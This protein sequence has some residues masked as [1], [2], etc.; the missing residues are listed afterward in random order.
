MRALLV[1][2]LHIGKKLLRSTLGASATRRQIAMLASLEA[3][4]VRARARY[5]I[6]VGDVFD[7][8]APSQEDMSALVDFWSTSKLRWIVYPG[9]H[10]VDDISLKKGETFSRRSSLT[11]LSRLPRAGALRNVMF[12]RTAKTV[13]IEGVRL[14]VV[15]WGHPMA[16]PKGT[17]L[18]LF[19]DSLVGAKRD[20]GSVV[21][22]GEG[23][24]SAA[25]RGFAAV[26]GHLHTPQRVRRTLFCGT[27]AQMSWGE[28]PVKQLYVTTVTQDF[29][30]HETIPW[31][32]PWTLRQVE[33]SSEAPPKLDDARAY[34]KLVV[35]N[36]QRVDPNWLV[37][38][39]N[40]ARVGGK[41]GQAKQ[42]R[43]IRQTRDTRAYLDEWLKRHTS[44]TD[45]QRAVALKIDARMGDMS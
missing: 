37:N 33:W 4:A 45:R 13:V 8:A 18:V 39:P 19:H 42:P 11:L 12:I 21:R 10:D 34:Y 14:H 24:S 41:G 28:R 22:D 40:V 44:L 5:A 9:N 27:A 38:N 17:N 15:P 23:L 3:E 43:I 16:P 7:T 2:D 25:L 26:S 30:S 6:V 1:G 32:P 20:S 35:P 36:G 31:T 29:V